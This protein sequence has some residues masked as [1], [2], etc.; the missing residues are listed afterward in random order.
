MDKIKDSKVDGDAGG[1]DWGCLLDVNTLNV[2]N[3]FQRWS[4][5]NSGF[6]Q[7]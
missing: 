2:H 7:S 3:Q 1:Y 5:R 4:Y 6:L